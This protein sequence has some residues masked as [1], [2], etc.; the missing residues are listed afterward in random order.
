MRAGS[1]GEPCTCED[2][3]NANITCVSDRKNFDNFLW[4]TITVFQVRLKS[5]P[6]CKP[7]INCTIIGF[8]ALNIV[9]TL[10]CMPS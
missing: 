10:A 8:N 4:S 3:N 1:S 9:S 2:L 6:T 5:Y 7:F